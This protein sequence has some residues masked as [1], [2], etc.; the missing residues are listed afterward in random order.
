MGVRPTDLQ[1]HEGNIEQIRGNSYLRTL[2]RSIVRSRGCP[3]G[4]VSPLDSLVSTI[5]IS[6]S[7]HKSELHVSL[8]LPS[9]RGSDVM[10]INPMVP[11]EDL[12]I[13]F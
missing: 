4:T 8:T 11:H 10:F 6:Y 2:S 7:R 12:I 9:D 3:T 13:S 5:G 1:R